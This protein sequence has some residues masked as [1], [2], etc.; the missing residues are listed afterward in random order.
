LENFTIEMILLFSDKE[1]R[2]GRR[3]QEGETDEVFNFG[4][5]G[6]QD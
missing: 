2:R 3:N 1:E 5:E 4:G 6:S